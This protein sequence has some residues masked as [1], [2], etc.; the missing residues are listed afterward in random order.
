MKQKLAAFFYGR[1][2]ADALAKGMLIAYI[3]LAVIMLFVDNTAKIILNLVSLTL[4]FL[5][6]YR[7]LSRNIAKRS[8]ENQIYL[9]TRKKIKEWILLQRNKWKYRKTHVY[10]RCPRCESLIRLP[11]RSGEHI[12]DCPKCG[13]AF[14]VKI[15]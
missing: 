7:M 14:D 6:F 9:H 2:G 4:C 15:R 5:M 1:Y 12:C 10:R 8:H 11:K 3:A 13:T